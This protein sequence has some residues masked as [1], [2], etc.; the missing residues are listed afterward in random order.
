MNFDLTFYWALFLR[1]LPVMALF[2]LL[3]SGFGIVAALKL[4]ET[5]RTS[6]RL[7]VEAPQIPSSMV[8]ST[9]QTDASEQLDIIE[10]KL[11]TRANLIDIAN[12]F[13]VFPD[14]RRMEPD[15]VVSNMETATRIQRSS[16]R[17]AA[18]LMT[19]SFTAHSPK[20]A[21]DVVNEYVTLVLEENADFRMTRAEN[22]LQFFEQE[23]KR[24]GEDLDGQS[25]AI[26]AF[27]AEHADALPEDQSYRLGRLSLIQERLSRLENDLEAAQMQREEV[28]RIFQTTGR[29]SEGGLVRRRS[30]EEERLM[31]ARTELENAKAIYTDSSPQVI[32]LQ[33]IVDRLEATVASNAAA[34][35]DEAETSPEQALLDAALAEIDNRLN[36]LTADIEST[37]SEMESLQQRI[38]AS[39]ANGIQLA[40]LERDYEV[41]QQRYNDAVNNLNEARMSERIET[42]AQGQRINVI[43]NANVPRLPSGPDRPKIA[44]MGALVGFGLAGAY[45]ALLEFLNRS[46]RRPA[47]LI[48]R[49]NV[50]PIA[51]IPYMESRRERLFRRA[52][53]ITAMLVVVASVPW[54]LWYIDSHYMP[55][56]VIVQKGLDTLGLG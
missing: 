46:I 30:P 48:G 17:D 26:A 27:K 56:E 32:R 41:I 54:G 55:L 35:E 11:L 21:A 44:I 13:N 38:T 28:V 24:L 37:K 25:S 51:T 15:S 34:A 9:V 10:Q 1:R 23:T 4:P 3:C 22:T 8:A 49:F 5:Y 7:L 16:N 33:A 20:I 29:V 43:E 40:A 18:T 14:I 2:V 39:A 19:I 47:E 36:A 45:F 12:R 50:T 31:A 52:G 6:A 42:T 53:L